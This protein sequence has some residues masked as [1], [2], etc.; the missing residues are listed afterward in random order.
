MSLCINPRCPAPQN[1]GNI[2]F[3]EACGS[4]LLLQGRYRAFNVL[5]G[6]GFGKTYEVKEGTTAVKVLKVLI[7]N[8][9][10]AVEL[11]QREA[12]VLSQLDN[13]G[14]PKVEKNSYFVFHPRDKILQGL[15]INV[16]A[17]RSSTPLPIS[18]PVP[19]SSQHQEEQK[20]ELTISELAILKRMI[21]FY[22]LNSYFIKIFMVFM[23]Q[24]L[25]NWEVSY[26]TKVIESTKLQAQKSKTKSK[27]RL[28]LEK[29]VSYFLLFIC[30]VI[31]LST[32]LK[33]LK[34][35]I[36]IGAGVITIIVSIYLNNINNKLIEYI[37]NKSR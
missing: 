11:F 21:P 4:E 32:A 13:L 26:F 20:K 16:S 2:L 3:C 9:P 28:W 36:F 31:I 7:N 15:K 37:N 27:T 35:L 19:A 1:P 18:E 30:Y 33:S 25:H 34:I 22:G 29:I 5:G 17:S 12:Q 6:G 8:S 23:G 10:K 24:S 14:I